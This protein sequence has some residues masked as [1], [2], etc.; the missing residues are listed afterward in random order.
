MP[1]M[2]SIVPASDAAGPR[3]LPALTAAAGASSRSTEPRRRLGS[4]TGVL[5]YL[6][7]VAL[8]AAATMAVFFGLAFSLLRQPAGPLMAELPTRDGSDV[9]VVRQDRSPHSGGATSAG[10]SSAAR[11]SAGPETAPAAVKTVLVLGG[12]VAAAAQ[13]PAPAAVGPMPKVAVS[14]TSKMATIPPSKAAAKIPAA[15]RLPDRQLAE[16]LARG[17]DFLRAGDIAS[18][19]LYYERAADAGDGQAALRVGATFD[20]AFLGR[21]GLRSMPGDPA[22]ALSWYR[23]ALVL[24]ASEAK[25]YL[26]NLETK[27]IKETK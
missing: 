6:V 12:G 18:A 13:Q 3:P 14:A 9:G 23:R 21:G 11:V 16:L 10:A 2:L 5:F 19:R 7:S 26:N 25:P 1:R 15:L 8:V 24:G 4:S 22:K 17:D 20:P 27:E